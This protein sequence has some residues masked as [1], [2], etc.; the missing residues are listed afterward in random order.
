MS[1]YGLITAILVALLFT[2]IFSYGFRNRGP[3]GNVWTFFLI[4]FLA[5]WAASFWIEPVGPYW[6]DITWIP[7]IFLGLIIALI[8]AAATPSERPVSAAEEEKAGPPEP[9]VA[10]VGVFF[11]LLLVVFVAAIII[12]IAS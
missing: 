6:G 8:L 9:A 10:I 7:L 3:W 12:G 11:W 4:L 5:V 2:I 1:I